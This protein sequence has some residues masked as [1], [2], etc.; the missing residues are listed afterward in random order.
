[1]QINHECPFCGQ[2]QIIVT[3]DG[4][5]TEEKLRELAAN[6][7]NCDEAKAFQGKGDMTTYACSSIKELCQD[8]RPAFRQ[9]LLDLVPYLADWDYDKV[10]VVS[11]GIKVT[12]TRKDGSIKVER[13]KSEKQVRG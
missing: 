9:G 12:L 8:D 11:E 3:G 13:A 5:F 10:S 7:C 1:M 2:M 6:Q 4:D